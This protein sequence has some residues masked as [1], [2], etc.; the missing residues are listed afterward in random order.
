MSS[1]FLGLRTVIYRVDDL[2]RATDWYARA[3]GFQPYFNQPY[4]V[5][6]NVGGYELGLLPEED[7]GPEKAENVEVYWGVDRIDAEYARLI[8]LGATAR[9]DPAEVGGDIW[10][11]TLKDPWGNLLGLIQNPHFEL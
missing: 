11:A 2:S 4:Y 1:P 9:R 10:V 8:S 5:G 6:F 7:A 3:L